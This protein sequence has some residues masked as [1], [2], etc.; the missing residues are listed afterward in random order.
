MFQYVSHHLQG[1]LV[2]S[3]LKTIGFYKAIGCGTL[4]VIKYITLLVYDTCTMVTDFVRFVTYRT[5]CS[6]L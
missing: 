3:L 5:A 4:I 1:E 2:H 6:I